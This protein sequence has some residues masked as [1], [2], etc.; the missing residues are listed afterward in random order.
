MKKVCVFT[1]ITF[2]KGKPGRASPCN[3][4]ELDNFKWKCEAYL[5]TNDVNRVKNAKGWKI[6][7][8]DSSLCKKYHTRKIARYVK[9]HPHTLLPECDVSLWIDGN[10]VLK[11]T[12]IDL[13][14]KFCQ[15]SF[16][17]QSICHPNRQST[18][19]E[20]RI[21]HSKK[22]DPRPIN[23]INQKVFYT[24]E[25]FPDKQ[26]LYE[27]KIVFRRSTEM[28]SHFNDLWWNIINRFTVRDQCSVMFALW[29]LNVVHNSLHYRDI[30]PHARQVAPGAHST[31]SYGHGVSRRLMKIYHNTRSYN[32]R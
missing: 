23:F 20:L 6:V 12:F 28:M 27:T 1:A 11:P 30:R 15:S 8:L 3:F 14:D 21:C 7:E 17:F 13:I 9:T 10:I 22:M 18:F 19:D 25:R 2:D 5:F 32:R 4:P 16:D 26:G 29:K 31:N 24:M